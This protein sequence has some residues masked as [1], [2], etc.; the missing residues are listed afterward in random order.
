MTFENNPAYRVAFEKNGVKAY[1]PANVSDFH[2][3]RYVELN[4]HMIYAGAG[5]T[6]DVIGSIVN[7]IL[8]RVDSDKPVATFRSDIAVLCNNL[9]YRLSTPVDEKASLRMGSVLCFLEGEDPNTCLGSWLDKKMELAANDPDWYS[10]FLTMGIEQQKV[11]NPLLSDI[12]ITE[13]Y[14]KNRRE[15]LRTLWPSNS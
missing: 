13:D 7:A 12:S 4:N 10:F 3:S 8:E 11:F 2:T 15:M 14:F 1:A 6:K 9:K 5:A